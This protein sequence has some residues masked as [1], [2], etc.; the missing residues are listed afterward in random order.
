MRRI[1]KHQVPEC[2]EN[3]I[4]NQLAIQPE[5]V[6]LTYKDFRPKAD[7]LAILTAE[8]FGLCGYTGVPIDERVLKLSSP[9]Q[10][11]KFNNHIEHLKCQKTCKEEL[12]QRGGE[13]GRDLCDDLNYFNMIAA[14]EVRGSKNEHFGAVKKRDCAL[15]ILPTQERCNEYFQFDEGNGGV[16]GLNDDA[17][18]SI[19][20][21]DLNHK[22][23]KDWRQAAI[24]S[25]LDPEVVQNRDDFEGVLQAM[26]TP[27]EGK[28]PEYA[29][30][31]GSIAK[32]Y[33]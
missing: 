33:L 6:N 8:Q 31:I 24:E 26:G 20:I 25:W 9:S 4:A 10:E 15:P 5:P 22:T 11:V 30:V 27:V 12:K 29:F 17:Q 21:L 3:F 13:V 28:L 18:E 2:L 32:G 16:T 7:L 19:K 1:A 23:L 14:I